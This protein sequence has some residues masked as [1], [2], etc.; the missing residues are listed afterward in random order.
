MGRPDPRGPGCDE[1]FPAAL[2]THL[3]RHEEAKTP[4]W[5]TTRGWIRI[6]LGGLS[7]LWGLCGHPSRICDPGE[8]PEPGAAAEALQEVTESRGTP[9]VPEVLLPTKL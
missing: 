6:T 1:A 2:E 4:L 5:L 9:S 3:R 8:E 7:S